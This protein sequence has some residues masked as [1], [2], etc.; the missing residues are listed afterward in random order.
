MMHYWNLLWDWNTLESPSVPAQLTAAFCSMR[1]PSNSKRSLMEQ[2][3]NG[4][5]TPGP[6]LDRLPAA[7]VLDTDRRYHR[8][9][10][11]GMYRVPP[12][13]STPS[14]CATLWDEVLAPHIKGRPD[15]KSGGPG[16][17]ARPIR[18]SGF[19]P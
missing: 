5:R 3:S 7:H 11:F 2:I 18:W 6:G 16:V 9:Q 19:S 12:T 15:D 1:T 10:E 14:S 4:L 8:L 17:P 13:H